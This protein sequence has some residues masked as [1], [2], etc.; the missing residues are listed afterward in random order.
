MSRPTITHVAYS[1]AIDSSLESCSKPS[2]KQ[3]DRRDSLVLVDALKKYGIRSSCSLT[4]LSG[5]SPKGQSHFG[6]NRFRALMLPKKLSISYLCRLL[7][8]R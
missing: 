3:I 7:P 2:L 8:V 5:T 6:A 1:N 4:A